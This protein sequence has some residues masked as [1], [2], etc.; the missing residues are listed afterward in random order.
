MT[1][2]DFL[3]TAHFRNFI[4]KKVLT[5]RQIK[6]FYMILTTK[7]FQIKEVLVECGNRMGSVLPFVQLQMYNILMYIKMYESSPVTLIIQCF[8][9]SR[10]FFYL[11][12]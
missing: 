1:R 9:N 11:V 7:P 5:A 2:L 8:P 10:F 3:Q 12:F 4:L 6:R